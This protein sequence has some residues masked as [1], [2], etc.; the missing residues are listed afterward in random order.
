MRHRALKSQVAK[1]RGNRKEV[2]SNIQ[3]EIEARLEESGIKATV[4]GREKH[5]YS[6]YKKNAQQRVTI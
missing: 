1:A 4:S 3:T 5:L 2:I 6:I